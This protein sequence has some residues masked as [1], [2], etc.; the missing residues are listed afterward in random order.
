MKKLLEFKK[1]TLIIACRN[2][3][4]IISACLDSVLHQ[5]YPADLMEIFVIDGMSDDGTRKILEKYS[6]KYPNLKIIDNINKTQPYAFNMGI[7]AS[8][9][10]Y[11]FIMGA[12]NKYPRHYVSKCLRYAESYN[13]DNVGGRIEARTDKK[14]IISEA[15][16]GSYTSP[17]GIGS[18]TFRKNIKKPIYVD[19]VFGGC[20]K[21]EVFKKIGLYNETLKRSQD[22]EL[23]LRLAR[24]GGKILLVPNIVSGYYPKT[25]F[26]EFIKYSFRAGKGPLRAMRT[27]GRPLKFMHYVPALFVIGLFGGI[28]SFLLLKDTFLSIL[29]LVVISV[30][31][32]LSMI[33]SVKYALRRKKFFLVILMPFIFF[34]KHFFYGLGSVYGF[35]KLND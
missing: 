7:K 19:T 12:H 9:G 4:D 3:V 30:Y 35:L 29:F 16:I 18:A 15:I 27:T 2:E 11:I 20:Y 32:T 14:D 10:D 31:F 17:F 24:S 13:T 1:A 26:A 8:S 28:L 6:K 23:N 34:T 33:F 22:M 5:D 25:N 21:K